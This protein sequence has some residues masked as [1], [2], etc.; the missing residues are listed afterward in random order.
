MQVEL[1]S[2]T[3]CE[4]FYRVGDEKLRLWAIVGGTLAI[5]FDDYTFQERKNYSEKFDSKLDLN[6][7]KWE[8]PRTSDFDGGESTLIDFVERNVPLRALRHA[9]KEIIRDILGLSNEYYNN[10]IS[11]R[12]HDKE[13]RTYMRCEFDLCDSI[14]PITC[15]SGCYW[16]RCERELHM[17]ANDAWKRLANALN[18]IFDNKRYTTWEQLTDEKFD[19]LKEEFR[20]FAQSKK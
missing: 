9:R 18:P 14:S 8:G 7:V 13:N 12:F 11:S 16:G 3:S 10:I 5:S 6:W 1:L 20:V 19:S 2:H 4:S 15:E 17:W